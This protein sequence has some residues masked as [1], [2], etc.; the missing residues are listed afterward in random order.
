MMGKN[1]EMIA[2]AG[3][4]LLMAMFLTF[5][6]ILTMYFIP[7]FVRFFIASGY[8]AFLGWFYTPKNRAKSKGRGR[9]R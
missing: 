7:L 5:V 1:N 9:A 6:G 4:L 2:F 3:V 8:L